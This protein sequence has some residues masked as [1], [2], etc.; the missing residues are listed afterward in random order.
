MAIEI[1]RKTEVNKLLWPIAFLVFSLIVF[2]TVLVSYF[3]FDSVYKEELSFL[4]EKQKSLV[5]TAEEK[6]LEDSLLGYQNKIDVFKKA[7]ERHKNV[8]NVFSFIEKTCHPKVYF[9]NISYDAGT[10][11]TSLEGSAADF[12]TVSQQVIIFKQQ[13]DVVKKV[14][15]ASLSPSE[16]GDVSFSL[17]LNVDPNIT[18]SQAKQ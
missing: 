18:A 3:Y 1:E 5:K 9:S 11:Q 13:K 7:F 8:L 14:S 6:A 15:L 17:V 4:I 2:I 12:M 10:G 16:K